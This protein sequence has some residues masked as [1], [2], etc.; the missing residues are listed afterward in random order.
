MPPLAANAIANLRLFHTVILANHTDRTDR[1]VKLLQ[2][3]HPLIVAFLFVPLNKAFSYP[4]ILA[5]LDYMRTIGRKNPAQRNIL[6]NTFV[7]SVYLYDDHLTIIFN[8]G[9]GQISVENI[10]FKK[11]EK[12]LKSGKVGTN[13]SS[14]VVTSVPANVRAEQ[15][16]EGQDRSCFQFRYMPLPCR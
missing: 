9:K 2:H 7:H 14:A 5:Y 4:Q 13:F 3:D 12:S 6:I 16:R 10:P 8:G 15:S 1:L 11:I